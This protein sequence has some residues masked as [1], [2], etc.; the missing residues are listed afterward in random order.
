MRFISSGGLSASD[1]K[2]LRAA[3]R[4]VG[5]SF[6]E[7]FSDIMITPLPTLTK[8]ATLAYVRDHFAHA[9]RVWFDSG[10]FGVQQGRMTYDDLY[11]ELTDWI[12]RN[13]W[14]HA[15][16]FPDFAPVGSLSAAETIYRV[17]ATLAVARWFVHALPDSIR[18][19]AI[20][21]V[22]GQ[23]A[24]HI[25]R[26]FAVYDDLGVR[27][28]AFGSFSVGGARRDIN[29]VTPQSLAL[30]RLVC[31]EAS[32]RGWTVH[33]FGV[34]TPTVI[35]HLAQVGVASF[36]SSCWIKTAGYGNVY[37][38]FLSRRNVTH[39]GVRDSLGPAYDEAT[40]TQLRAQTGHSCPWCES[41]AVLQTNRIAR[42]LHNLAVIRDMLAHPVASSEPNRVVNRCGDSACTSTL[43]LV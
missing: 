14:G 1:W 27:S 8:P 19:R 35:P 7:W 42:A 25:H 24:D 20:P 21:V 28:V 29:L 32:R 43:P 9:H 33:A 30:L 41:F 2:A 23:T 31:A 6:E 10:G 38:P 3:C 22:V 5:V 34:G 37:L 39:H 17:E 40:F 26:C 15:Y 4:H 12:A 11:R 16:M 13:P 18:D 36:D